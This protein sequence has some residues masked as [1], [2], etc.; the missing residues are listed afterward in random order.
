[1]KRAT[2]TVFL[3]AGLLAVFAVGLVLVPTGMR[4]RAADIGYVEDFALARDR[5]VA[6]KQLIPGT[7]DYYY[8][9]ALH[10]LNTGRFEEALAN[11]KPWIERHGH[12]ARVTEIQ[13]RHALLTYEKNPKK[14]V[15]FLRA[16]DR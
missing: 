1:M 5:V 15:D 8:Y 14:S 4:A 11:F 3:P 16:Q 13:V 10:A 2:A 7:E 6:L 9:H 12:T